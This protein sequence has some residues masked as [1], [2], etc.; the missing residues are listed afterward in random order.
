MTFISLSIETYVSQIK[1]TNNCISC[2][3]YYITGSTGLSAEPPVQNSSEEPLPKAQIA[4]VTHCRN[5]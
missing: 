4:F 1:I 3:S 5:K 2:S